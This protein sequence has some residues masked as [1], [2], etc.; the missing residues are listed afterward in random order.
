V[1]SVLIFFQVQMQV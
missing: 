1:K